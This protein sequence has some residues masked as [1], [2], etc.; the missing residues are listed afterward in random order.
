MPNEENKG[1]TKAKETN[2]GSSSL[3]LGHGAVNRLSGTSPGWGVP[4]PG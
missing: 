4:E 2:R 3:A 1:R